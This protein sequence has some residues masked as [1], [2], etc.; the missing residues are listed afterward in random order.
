MP[1]D[2]TTGSYLKTRQDT[3]LSPVQRRRLAQNPGAVDPDPGDQPFEMMPVLKDIG[4]GIIETPTQIVGGIGDAAKETSEALGSLLKWVGAEEVGKFF[5]GETVVGIPTE[6]GEEF[7][8]VPKEELKPGE[9]V[10]TGLSAIKQ[11]TTV[12]G[13]LVRD[14]SQFLAGFLPA[15]KAV[16]AVAK[17]GPIVTSAI[18]G[19]VAD[20]TVFDPHEDRLS[21]LIESN[22][23]LQNPVSEYLAAQPDDTEAEGRFKN[24]LEGFGLGVLSEGLFLAAKGIRANRVRKIAE[25]AAADEK[26]TIERVAATG[27]APKIE[28]PEEGFKTIDETDAPTFQ[29]GGPK[30]K[31]EAAQNIN[32]SKLD[33]GEDV[34]EL[35]AR[36]GKKFSKDINEARREKITN[37]ETAKLADDLG[38]TVET[39][40]ARRKG[41]AFNAEQAV[42]ARKILV[43]SGENLVEL[44]KAASAGADVDVLKF[45]KAMANH[46]AIQLQVSGATAEAGRALQSFRIIAKSEE[47]Q[48][49]AIKDALEAGGGVRNSRD[50]ADQLLQLEHPGQINA[51]VKQSL[52]AKTKAMVYEAWIN[53]L[54]S[55]PATHV[56]N[57]LGNSITAAW[58]VGERK[59]ASMIGAG[60]DF[61]SIPEGEATASLF[62]MV[63]GAKDGMVLAAKALKTGQPADIVT[64]IETH[65]RRA[66]TGENLNL[67][68]TAGRFADFVGETVRLPGRFL[69]A[70]DEFFKS[71]GYRMELQGQAFRQAS[72]EGLEGDALARRINEIVENPPENLELA[73]VDASRYQ[74]FTKPLGEGGQAVQN[75]TQK[76]PAARI[77]VPFIRTPV[78][79]M[80][81]AGERTALAPLSKS[82]RAEITAGGARRDLALAKIATGSMIMA[83]AADYTTSG[84][85]TGGGPQNPAM[86][87]LLRTTG[88]Q[89]YSIKVDDTYYAYSR[90]DPIGALIGMAADISEIIGQTNETDALDLA[91]AATVA[92]AQNVTSKTYLRGV[93]EFFDVMSSVSP[94]PNAKNKRA[95]RWVERLAGSAVPAG[96]A[97]LER[98]LSPEL[99]ATQGILEKIRSRI[100][101]YSD[102]LPPRRNIF[103]EPIVLSGGLGP[104]IMSPI[105]TSTDKKDPIA[106]EIVKQQT[107]LRMPRNIIQGVE[108]DTQQYDKYISLYAG[109]NNRFVK[110]PLKEQLREMM[111]S[112]IYQTA[113]DGQE[114]G[115][116]TLIKAVF[117]AYRN[118]AQGAMMEEDPKLFTE[119]QDLKREKAIK[120]GAGQ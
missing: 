26:T 6:P 85:V 43:A 56:V 24:A 115:K 87:N 114:G 82:V 49:Q 17:T 119:I 58:S 100:P 13:G 80:K 14:V 22:P 88:W 64:K 77:I 78:N 28:A 1:L 118:S 39:L 79:I 75:F 51:F 9:E 7:G 16:G 4:R 107:L 19:A 98:T 37:E 113:T 8:L 70:G 101:G 46:H 12:T 84:Q 91:T 120:L 62:G 29:I 61:Q 53:G 92:V 36:T 73:A 41:E 48:T 117:E 102:D 81:Y 47:A 20:A 112:N 111:D 10:E 104:D 83:A 65:G 116:S 34:K 96:V 50:L 42:A 69:T 35:I 63:Q 90:L 94:D 25:K 23:D 38:M 57:V 52:G 40:L 5:T 66:I 60:L 67:S 31:P 30:A 21:N 109:E 18:A 105:Y 86:R 74:T 97:Q 15:S 27:E 89:P 44:A 93:A 108:L 72:S 45:R 54:L 106:D 103:G 110:M 2:D 33:T 59:V 71:V 32:L 3:E 11:P 99:E 95:S 68:G 76:V 55:S